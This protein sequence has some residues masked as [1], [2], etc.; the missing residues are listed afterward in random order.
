VSFP[1]GNGANAHYTITID[2]AE[3]PINAPSLLRANGSLTLAGDP[4]SFSS[5]TTIEVN[6]NQILTI[7]CRLTK[8]FTGG[9]VFSKSGDGMLV[10]GRAQR[11][12]GATAI[13]RGT[14]TLG[15]AE[16]L[17]STS[18]LILGSNHTTS[19]FSTGGFDQ[20]LRYLILNDT[21]GLGETTI[22]FGA[23]DGESTLSFSDSSRKSWPEGS[24]LTLKNY[25]PSKTRLRFGTDGGGLTQAQLAQ[26]RFD[27]NT[28][29]RIDESGYVTPLPFLITKVER[30][31]ATGHVTVTFNST[32]N[33]NFAIMRTEDL[34]TWLELE[35]DIE[36]EGET[37]SYT[38]KWA[39]PDAREYY[40]SVVKTP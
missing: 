5:A 16:V 22:D 15:G 23:G 2:N 35:D 28:S 3:G 31:S 39:E 25:V 18:D 30:D 34:E 32:A 26:I 20:K 11:Y 4:L 1:S 36:A 14:L 33:Q 10:V 12:S 40:Y 37:T 29:A 27:A 38:D 21:G 7:D 19:R 8:D 9:T 13:A 24:L 6:A 17:P